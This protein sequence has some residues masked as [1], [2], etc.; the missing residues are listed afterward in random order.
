MK[1]FSF[2]EFRP[3]IF[4]LAKFVGIYIIGNL[5][6]GLF[7]T[8]YKP[9]PDPVTRWVT[10]QT[11][12]AL[13]I[14]GHQAVATD[15]DK[16]A[17]TLVVYKKDPVISVFEGCNGINIFIVF[18]GF[19]IA[20][21]PYRK[22]LL[23]FLPAGLLIIHIFNIA[24]IGGLFMISL[25]RPHWLYFTHKYLFTAFIYLVVFLLWLW[26]IRCYSFKKQK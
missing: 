5:L 12:N 21:G 20:F 9:N 10:Q 1:K 14:T 18:A 11:V 16:K 6:Y 15:H 19:L 26:W 4:F 3:T 8:Y 13:N 24:R 17:T 2:D 7:V 23:W 22:T 25:Y